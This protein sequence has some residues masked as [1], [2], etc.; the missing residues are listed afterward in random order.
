MSGG[1]RAGAQGRV[2]SIAPTIFPPPPPSLPLQSIITVNG[3][4]SL[5]NTTRT[6][7]VNQFKTLYLMSPNATAFTFEYPGSPQPVCRYNLG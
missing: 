4:V 5:S 2:A 1:V 7:V 3:L 6:D